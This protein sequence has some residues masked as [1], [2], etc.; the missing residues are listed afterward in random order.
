MHRVYTYCG[1]EIDIIA[2]TPS[3]SWIHRIDVVVETA[4]GCAIDMDIVRSSSVTTITLP[5]KL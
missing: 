4:I 3:T 1:L 2:T 5:S